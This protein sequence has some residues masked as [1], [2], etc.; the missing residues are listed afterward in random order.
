MKTR[1]MWS[2]V[3]RVFVILAF[4]LLHL[5][6]VPAGASAIQ[7]SGLV[8]D[9]TYVLETTGE[10][11]TWD[12]PWTFDEE[13]SEAGDEFEIVA[14]T[15]EASSLLISLL[16]SGLQIEQARDIVLDEFAS[17]A[18]DFTTIDREAYDDISYSLD[19]ADIDGDDLGVFTLFRAG[20]GN[21][22]TY[23]YIFISAV[24]AF[25]DDFESSQEE[26]AIDGDPIFNGVDGADL[27]SQLEE[28]AGTA[29][30]RTEE[31]EETEESDSSSAIFETSD[32]TPEIDEDVDNAGTSSRNDDEIDEEFIDLGVVSQREYESPQFGT[33]LIW[34]EPWALYEDADEP[35]VS[36][37]DEETDIIN[38]VWDGDGVSLLR[39][40]F[41]PAGDITPV[42]AVEVWTSDDFLGDDAEVLL[43]DSGRDVGGVVT[44]EQTEQGA[45]IVVY[46][47]AHLLDD[48]ETLGVITYL[49]EPVAVEDSLLDAQDVVELDGEPVLARFDAEDVAEA[50]D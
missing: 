42:R 32:R 27:Q 14:L 5:G 39:V 50:V 24:Q 1:R 40:E 34:D 12:D 8:D 36:D 46:R 22:P 28:S 38:L 43:E 7:D 30:E 4:G 48:G 2:V 29:P 10:E 15:G 18:D 26:I 31:A 47:E 20:S 13:T 16:P 35:V 11:V 3:L 6:A 9:T 33:E 41:I 37:T 21:T 25:G 45:E 23:A 19:L 44:L 17:G 49:A